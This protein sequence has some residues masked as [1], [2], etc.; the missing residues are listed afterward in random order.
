MTVNYCAHGKLKTRKIRS[1]VRPGGRVRHL[2]VVIE[3]LQSYNSFTVAVKF[4][5]FPQIASVKA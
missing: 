5:F 3:N 2:P 4:E 1:L